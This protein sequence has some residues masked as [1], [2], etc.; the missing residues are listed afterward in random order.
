MPVWVNTGFSVASQ[1]QHLYPMLASPGPP[2]LITQG[3]WPRHISKE[4]SAYITETQVI[5][6]QVFQIRWWVSRYHRWGYLWKPFSE[7]PH[8]HLVNEKSKSYH[9]Y[10]QLRH[11]AGR[12]SGV[13]SF[14]KKV[15][16]VM[17]KAR[18]G[19]YSW[20]SGIKATGRGVWKE[21][22]TSKTVTLCPGALV[23][24][25]V[26]SGGRP[27]CFS[28]FSHLCHGINIKL[29]MKKMEFWK[30]KF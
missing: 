13:L 20:N 27:M 18:D 10:L 15:L 26:L 25:V 7:N 8:N 5:V 1:H 21:E 19:L 11:E 22:E 9:F 4:G 17:E 2:H 30:N 23:N 24:Q 14:P 12:A 28:Y 6:S 16:Y 29:R 3:S